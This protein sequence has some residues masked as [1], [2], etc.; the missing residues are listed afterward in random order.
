MEVDGAP[1]CRVSLVRGGLR[2]GHKFMSNQ[3]SSRVA[4]LE[5]RML[6][7]CAALE[8]ATG[9]SA[10]NPVGLPT[11]VR[12]WDPRPYCLAHS[13]LCAKRS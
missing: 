6:D 12:L 11:Q 2:A 8:A 10:A 5:T 13:K 4:F 1:R 7:F 3:V 9:C